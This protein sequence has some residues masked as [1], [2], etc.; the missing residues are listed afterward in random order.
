MKKCF[1]KNP[2]FKDRE[3]ENLL[4]KLKAVLLLSCFILVGTAGFAQK[5]SYTLWRNGK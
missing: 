5:G 1:R 4:H 3:G 2:Y